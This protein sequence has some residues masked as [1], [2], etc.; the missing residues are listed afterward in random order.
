MRGNGLKNGEAIAARKEIINGHVS[1]LSKGLEGEV[2]WKG[3]I[4]AVR[5]LY[6]AAGFN[7]A[8]IMRMGGRRILLSVNDLE[9]PVQALSD[10]L[11]GVIRA[12]HLSQLLEARSITLP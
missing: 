1:W 8:R 2:R 6:H 12:V 9:K 4:P 11:N 5:G 10:F 7:G 3:A